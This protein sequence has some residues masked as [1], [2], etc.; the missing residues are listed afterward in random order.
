MGV[1]HFSPLYNHTLATIDPTLLAR[2]YYFPASRA[3]FPRVPR[4]PWQAGHSTR[5]S[6]GSSSGIYE[7]HLTSTGSLRPLLAL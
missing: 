4:L 1:Y 5:R 3:I 2:L 6:L 7:L